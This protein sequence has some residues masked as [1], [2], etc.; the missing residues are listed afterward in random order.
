QRDVTLDDGSVVVLAPDSRLTVLS[1][2]GAGSRDV[3]LTGQ[4][5]FQ[6]AHDA[7]R[8]LR[9][10][11]GA[12]TTEVLGTRFVVRAYRDDEAITVALVEGSV[13]VSAVG[14]A[15]AASAITLIPGQI[16]RAGDDSLHIDTEASIGP[17]LAWTE[18]QLMFDD[19]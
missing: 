13:R 15:R 14:D 9:V 8:P 5:V 1:A 4:A 11:A 16:A 6:V 7:T 17:W 12:L 10:R 18:G 19:T 3:E 2:S